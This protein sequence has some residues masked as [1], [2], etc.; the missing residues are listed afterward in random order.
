MQQLTFNPSSVEQLT[1]SNGLS[2]SSF[3]ARVGVQQLSVMAWI[4]GVY[5]PSV[6]SLLKMM[7]TFGVDANYFF[8]EVS[9]GSDVLS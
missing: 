2:L 5:Q 9:G 7:N 1:F 4:K 6:Q 3:C 8:R